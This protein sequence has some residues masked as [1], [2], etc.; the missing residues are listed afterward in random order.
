[1]NG[2]LQTGP[3]GKPYGIAYVGDLG[4]LVVNR[5]GYEIYPEWDPTAEANKIEA[6]KTRR[7]DRI[8]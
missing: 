7:N 2:G 3:Y 6:K 8:A 5:S 1:M 4:T